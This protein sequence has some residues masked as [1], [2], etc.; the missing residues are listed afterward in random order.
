[1][2]HYRLLYFI[3]SI[4]MLVGQFE[5]SQ[6][7]SW[8]DMQEKLFHEAFVAF[9]VAGLVTLGIESV[10]QREQI[11]RV[12]EYVRRI[13]KN[14]WVSVYGADVPKDVADYVVAKFVHYPFCETIEN[15]TIT[16][17]IEDEKKRQK[18]SSE[19]VSYD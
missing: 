1:M 7:I 16:L 12:D 14:V 5:V 18:V 15:V 8:P 3:V 10:S 11:K 4:V 13:S 17:E 9:F 2:T 19:L 6:S